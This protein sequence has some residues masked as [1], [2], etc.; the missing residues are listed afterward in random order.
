MSSPWDSD[1][2]LH[3]RPLDSTQRLGNGRRQE[4]GYDAQVGPCVIV[5]VLS[6]SGCPPSRC[7][8]QLAADTGPRGWGWQDT[9]ASGKGI[10]LGVT[11]RSQPLSRS[12]MLASSALWVNSLVHSAGGDCWWL[13]IRGW[14]HFWTCAHLGPSGWGA[15]SYCRSATLSCPLWAH[16]PRV[17][18]LTLVGEEGLGSGKSHLFMPTQEFKRLMAFIFNNSEQN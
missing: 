3:F 6:S 2:L 15:T 1:G 7:W 14:A 10:S 8:K 18:V 4:K 12:G 11:L 13:C 17:L 5:P 16:L 9:L